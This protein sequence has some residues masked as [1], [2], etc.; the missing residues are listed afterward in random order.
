MPKDG[1]RRTRGS[2]TI[3]DR[4]EGVWQIRYVVGY[5]PDGQPKQR[6]EN[7]KGTRRQAE[8]VLRERLAAVETGNYVERKKETLAAFLDSWL[9]IHAATHVSPRTLKEYRGSVKHIVNGMGHIQVQALTPRHIVN[10][11]K[12]L[13][14]SGL[15]NSLSSIAIGCSIMPL[16]S[17]LNGESSPATQ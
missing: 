16:K 12:Q 4:G 14:D 7:I 3:R 6:A 1:P 5:R 8:K 10:F 13:Q 15:S 11:H 17:L 9:S 2:G